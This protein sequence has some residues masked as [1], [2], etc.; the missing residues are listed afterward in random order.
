MKLKKAAI[1]I[2]L[3]MLAV[4]SVF[5]QK[6]TINFWT[7]RPEDVETYDKL[8]AVFNKANP[9]PLLHSMFKTEGTVTMGV[10]HD[11]T[12]ARLYQKSLEENLAS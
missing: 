1:L 10:I 12:A 6:T 2:L 9:D 5:A 8:I 11:I 7:W 3:A 4:S